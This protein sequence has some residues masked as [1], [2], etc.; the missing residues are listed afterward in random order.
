MECDIVRKIRT[1]ENVQ[2]DSLF[3]INDTDKAQNAEK[4]KR[5]LRGLCCVCALM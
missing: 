2:Y 4:T 5:S 3:L 1:Q